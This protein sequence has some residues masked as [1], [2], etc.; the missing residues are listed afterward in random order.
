MLD[1]KER[2]LKAFLAHQTGSP[3]FL[4]AD[5]CSSKLVG[6][7]LLARLCRMLMYSGERHEG[8]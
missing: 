7:E 5:G 6:I 2:L 3:E 8:R 4:T 1:T